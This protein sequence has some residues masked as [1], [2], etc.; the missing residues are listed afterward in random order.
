[1]ADSLTASPGKPGTLKFKCVLWANC[2]IFERVNQD[3]AFIF[4]PETMQYAPQP[5][6]NRLLTIPGLDGAYLRPLPSFYLHNFVCFVKKE[7]EEEFQDPSKQAIRSILRSVNPFSW[8]DVIPITSLEYLGL[9]NGIA[10][11]MLVVKNGQATSS[12]VGT[13]QT[14]IADASL[15]CDTN[16]LPSEYDSVQK[17]AI[18]KE[19]V[20]K[21]FCT[22]WE[23]IVDNVG[24]SLGI[25]SQ[26]TQDGGTLTTVA[27]LKNN[28]VLV[29][30][31]KGI[32]S[33]DDPIKMMK[34]NG[35]ESDFQV[36]T[37]TYRSINPGMHWRMLK[38]T[39][40]FQGEDFVVEFSTKAPASTNIGSKDVKFRMLDKFKFLD[41][42]SRNE[43]AVCGALN[44]DG[45]LDPKRNQEIIDET[46]K[47]FDFSRQMYYM[48]EIGVGDPNHNYW[49]I[50]AE[51]SYPIFCH[52]G[53]VATLTCRV[54][55]DTPTQT[56]E[57]PA[58]SNSSDEIP[59][60][61]TNE[62]SGGSRQAL[63]ESAF[64][65]PTPLKEVITASVG[66]NPTL[67]KLSTYEGA[68]SL[69]LL[70]KNEK[71][72]I[73]V[74]QHGGNIVITFSGFESQPW[75]VSRKDIDESATPISQGID[76]P[77][78][79]SQVV[80]KAVSMLIPFGQIALM[81][82][83]RKCGFSF[84]PVIY[85]ELNEYMMPQPFSV[86]GP[87]SVDEIQFLWRDKGKSLNP[88]VSVNLNKPQ[89]TNEAG[90]YKEIAIKPKDTSGK[91]KPVTTYAIENQYWLTRTRGKAPD[92]M[93]NNKA[94]EK[95]IRESILQINASECTTDQGSKS[96]NSKLMQVVISATPGGYLFPAIDGG[97]DWALKN[98][99][100]PILYLFR[101]YVPPKGCIF[102]KAP[103]DVSQHVLSFS[104]E[105]S[106]TDWQKLEHS[107]S[108][109]F[110]I[111]DGM[112][113]R[114][115]QSNYLYSLVDKAFYLQISLWWE[116]GI[117]PT[118]TDPKD[119]IVFTGFCQG[120]VI[121]TETN[122]KTLDCKVMDYSKILKDQFFL[123]S[124]FFDRMRDVNAVRDILRLAGLRDGEDNNSSIEPGSLISVLANSESKGGWYTFHFNGDKIYNREY[125]LP[126]SY[127]TLQSPFLR[128]TDGSS[129]WDA[130]EKMALLSNKVAF[131]DRL[132]VF[133]FNPL[134]YD[135]EIW[136][137]QSGSQTNWTIQDWAQ[138][139]KVDFFATPKQ[140]N[141]S[142]GCAPLNRQIIGDYKVERVVQDVV[143]EIKVISTSPNGEIFVA[144]HTNYAS[145]TDPDS[146]GF[147]GYRKSFLQ[148]DGIF[149]SEDTVKWVVKNYTRMFIPPIK[150]S[151][152]AIGRN[153]IKALDVITFQPIGSREKQP[154][155][156]TSVK[157]EVD[158]SKGT[159]FQDF[160]CLW[161][162]P[163]QDVQWGNTNEIG[164][165]LDGSISGSITGA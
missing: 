1:M 49:I 24:Q 12:A 78:S 41:V 149:G 141:V 70:K 107:G 100:T 152:R 56:E 19:K 37:N 133:H 45:L 103:V 163:R 79:E 51:N 81:G 94:Y 95:G 117:M 39:P 122:K 69:T 8:D 5:L 6:K 55:E 43:A 4:S 15:Y 140:L 42:F 57:P 101:M 144:G 34:D 96:Q 127:D 139:S 120:G 3:Q 86:Q 14:W 111:S 9:T 125:A 129:Y 40:I 64:F 150:V 92:M 121:T 102:Q 142:A 113:F 147:L 11:D 93:K 26:S 53:K 46:K 119:R 160:E 74:R 72:R 47:V 35:V 137:G 76:I 66:K 126:G 114:N 67:R 123:N 131:F 97:S 112:K 32:F 135:Q 154:L 156:I 132:G 62:Q 162:F 71:L 38:R 10:S 30:V 146:P 16:L 27:Q 54:E 145:L 110:L 143:N 115:N 68:S 58:R 23:Y 44:G 20:K 21:S 77:I 108:I 50:I 105:W 99:I 153:D 104:D 84:S 60:C 158:P 91:V 138:L 89:Y 98:C 90:V 80:Y 148:M 165:G 161:L 118:P 116:N 151:F 159:W 17:I 13:H 18:A 82:G 106:E 63:D 52:V 36:A 88:E 7:A 136:G 134:P 59:K 28:S 124:P 83:N 33:P 2:P 85:S 73:M 157:S 75:I 22:K 61:S 65:E 25:L 48:I 155:V 130:I 29:P 164:L 109:S 31:T 128:F 87:V